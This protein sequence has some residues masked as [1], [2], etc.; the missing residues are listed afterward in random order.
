M[1]FTYKRKK[2]NL[3]IKEI[4]IIAIIAIAVLML[5]YDKTTDDVDNFR[6]GFPIESIRD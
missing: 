2:I 3:S 4:F 1:K 6:F 5:S